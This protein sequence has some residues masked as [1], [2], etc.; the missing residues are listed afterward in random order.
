MLALSKINLLLYGEEHEALLDGAGFEF[1]SGP[2]GQELVRAKR[3]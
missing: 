2:M 3:K 1:Y